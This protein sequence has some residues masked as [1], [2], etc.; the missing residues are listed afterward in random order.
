MEKMSGWYGGGVLWLLIF[1]VPVGVAGAASLPQEE[2]ASMAA[3]LSA[4]AGQLTVLEARVDA[5]TALARSGAAVHSRADAQ[6]AARTK[7]RLP[8]DS[9][10]RFSQGWYVAL[11]DTAGGAPLLW[12]GTHD[13][14]DRV[15]WAQVQA[16][17]G[18]DVRHIT[19]F[20]VF[21]ERTSRFDAYIERYAPEQW[22]LGINAFDLSTEDAR[23]SPS[24]VR[25]LVHEY[26]HLLL[27]GRPEL[28]AAIRALWRP[29]DISYAAAL[30]ADDTAALRE[31]LNRRYEER[32][33]AFVSEYAL[34]S[35]AEDAAETFVSFVLD[36]PQ[37]P[38][39]IAKRKV[40]V[41]DND[42]ELWRTREVL[43]VRLGIY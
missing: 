5:H 31:A 28:E 18:T 3:L 42:K 24:L 36:A 7:V 26:A 19:T 6:R 29:E 8:P 15:L 39:T 41:F 4:L 16:V 14:I 12:G 32:S 30:E 37:A 25:L 43:R 20:R 40:A 23:H 35:P 10:A 38:H 17:F 13:P 9:P 33:H 34:L 2:R 22:V 11:Y 1:L 27:D 21:Y